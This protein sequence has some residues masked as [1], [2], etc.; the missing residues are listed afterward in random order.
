[1]RILLGLG[2][3]G[4]EIIGKFIENVKIKNG[5]AQVKKSATLLKIFT[6]QVLFKEFR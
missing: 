2:P 1:M 6:S 4:R 3:T 5:K